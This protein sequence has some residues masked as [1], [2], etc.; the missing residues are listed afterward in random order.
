LLI[1][2]ALGGLGAVLVAADVDLARR[3]RHLLRPAAPM[4]TI[5]TREEWGA[6]PPNHNAENEQGFAE[7]PT[8]E[9]WLVYTKPLD[10]VYNTVVIHHSAT[11]LAANETMPSLQRLH[12]NVNGW[13]DVG[14][15]Y[16]I[17]R[18]GVIYEG[19]DMQVRGASV[20]GHNTGIVGVVVMG[21]FEQ[22]QPLAIQLS[23]LQNLINWLT[24]AYFLTHLA[25]HSEFNPQSTCPGRNL[26]VYLDEFA[27]KADL[28]RG[29]GGYVSPI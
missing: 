10:E 16:A 14:Y 21:N 6:L 17:D 24:S 7:S 1:A 25:G 28:E 8:D 26:A 22:D 20:E 13:A 9:G 18:N 29:T 4:P 5:I 12:L 2:T 23:A 27:Q 15:H 11:R 3:I 19:R